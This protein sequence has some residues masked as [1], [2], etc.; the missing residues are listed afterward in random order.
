MKK[1]LSSLISLFLFTFVIF[2]SGCARDSELL[3][4]QASIQ[5]D[6]EEIKKLL[7]ERPTRSVS[8]DRSFKPTDISIKG[9]PFLGKSDAPV[10]LVEFTD[11]QCPYCRR[12]A[13]GT[14]K[15]IIK[16]YVDTGKVKYV[17]REFPLS[18]IHPK[19]HKLSQAALCAGDQNKY[20]EMHDLFL[21][22][23]K[24]INPDDLSQE[25][26]ALDL[27][28]QAFQTCLDSNK[29]AKKVDAD[30]T[31]GSKL[32]V[33]G[34]PSFFIGKTG[35]QGNTKIHATRMLRGAQS[36]EQFRQAIDKALK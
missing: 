18:R 25:I 24:K 15:Q 27:D 22:G 33:R 19:A 30:V 12:H 20:W 14:G 7:K 1:I 6:L 35:K 13:N 16:E 21:K 11:Y 2:I 28:A 9:S 32:G 3:Q 26:K 5:Q 29:Y 17:I 31:D 4:G 10:T 23:T 8:R 34:T 36:F